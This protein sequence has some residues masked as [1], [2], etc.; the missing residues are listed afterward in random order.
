[1]YV[2]VLTDGTT[3]DCTDYEETDT[4]VEFAGP[5]DEVVAF[6]PYHGVRYVYRADGSTELRRG[7]RREDDND[8]DDSNPDSNDN[9]GDPCAACRSAV[10]ESEASAA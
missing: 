4:G 9:D 5:D 6:A 1:M 10:P 2:A 8:N 7:G 3:F